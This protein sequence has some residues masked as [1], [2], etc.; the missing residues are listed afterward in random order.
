[1]D[2][3]NDDS[4]FSPL[5]SP[6]MKVLH[7]LIPEFFAPDVPALIVGISDGET[8]TMRAHPVGP[9]GDIMGDEWCNLA[10]DVKLNLACDMAREI[11]SNS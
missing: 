4:G 1:M 10:A 8:L 2:C 3:P 7:K 9:L 11:K 5:P 6:P